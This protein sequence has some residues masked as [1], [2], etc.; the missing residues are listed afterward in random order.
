M[1]VSY[2][3]YQ[4]SSIAQNIK[5]W[6][7]LNTSIRFVANL[8][9]KEYSKEEFP[10]VNL[11]IHNMNGKRTARIRIYTGINVSK[12]K[13]C[14]VYKATIPPESVFEGILPIKAGRFRRSSEQRAGIYIKQKKVTIGKTIKLIFNIAL[15]FICG[16]G[17]KG[18]VQGL[19]L[20][21]SII[22]EG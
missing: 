4:E 19:S 1:D 20:P 10:A 13:Q 7:K 8:T 21:F 11:I 15:G 14:N 9:K 17:L 3:Q 16:L 18:K 6:V 2:L 5:Y 12:I 22:Q